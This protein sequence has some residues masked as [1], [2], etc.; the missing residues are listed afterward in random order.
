MRRLYKKQNKKGNLTEMTFTF[1]TG[2]HVECMNVFSEKLNVCK[3]GLFKYKEKFANYMG[4][5]DVHEFEMYIHGKINPNTYRC[6]RTSRSLGM[7]KL[8][9]FVDLTSY[10]F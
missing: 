1:P 6:W 7:S 3:H 9:R 4:F 2:T 8:V 5:S 10:E